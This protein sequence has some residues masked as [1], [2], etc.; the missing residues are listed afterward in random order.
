MYH[1]RLLNQVGGEGKEEV[2]ASARIA[3]LRRDE[4]SI[5]DLL[6]RGGAECLDGLPERAGAEGPG[7]RR[8]ARE[9]RERMLLHER[10]RAERAARVEQRRS[11]IGRSPL[12]GVGS[13]G[14]NQGGA[15]DQE[16]SI[17]GSEPTAASNAARVTRH[18]P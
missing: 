10:R 15:G 11:D 16:S 17:R 2:R 13:A 9:E 18:E 7:R 4:V 5:R 3:G 12:V 14:A 1:G 8:R 6:R